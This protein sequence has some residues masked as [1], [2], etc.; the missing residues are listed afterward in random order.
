VNDREWINEEIKFVQKIINKKI[1]TLGIC[2]G[3]QLIAKALLGHNGVRRAPTP[4]IGWK[5]VTVNTENPLFSKI[6]KEFYIFMSHFDEVCNLSKDFRI[7][8]SSKFCSVQAFQI[9]DA[10]A[11]GIQFHPEID[12]DSGKKSIKDLK[13]LY[14]NL[15]VDFD[16]IIE[17]T[18]DS[19]ISQKFFENFFNIK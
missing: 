7:L 3:H 11:W 9:I 10:P 12:I 18:K 15:N 16:Q 17:E 19:G 13:Q 14:P 6:D 8:A 4:E 2:F 1:P 5:K